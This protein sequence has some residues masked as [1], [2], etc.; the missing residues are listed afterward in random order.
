MYSPIAKVFTIFQSG[1]FK[2]GLTW[3]YK[4]MKKYVKLL[5]SIFREMT[6][7]S[8]NRLDPTGNW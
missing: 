3:K 7:G 6:F 4:T 2:K 8:Y 1:G 5:Y